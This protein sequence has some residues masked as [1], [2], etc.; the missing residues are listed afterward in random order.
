MPRNDL[1][2]AEEGVFTEQMRQRV[3]HNFTDVCTSTADLAKTSSTTQAVIPGLVTDTLVAGATYQFE[4][5]LKVTQT[6]NG[7]LTLEFN[8]P[9]TLTLTSISYETEE[10]TASVVALAQ[11]T[12]AT[13]ATKI[14]DN[15]TAAYIS[16]RVRGSFVV[17]A[18]GKFELTAA[19]NT[20]HSD[21][22]TIS[23]GSTLRVWGQIADTEI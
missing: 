21:T 8:T 16:V 15:K 20:S 19:Q 4:A 5:W 23:K 9:D 3:N 11:G 18:A 12:T 17:K 22:T 7:G 10:A 13:M 14:V 1:P 2:S 6:T